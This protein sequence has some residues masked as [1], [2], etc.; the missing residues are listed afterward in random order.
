MKKQV[1][2]RNIPYHIFVPIRIQKN[3]CLSYLLLNDVKFVEYT[4]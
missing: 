3:I 2:A 1:S 4:G